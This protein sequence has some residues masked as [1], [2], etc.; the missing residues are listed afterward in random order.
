MLRAR[1]WRK[2]DLQVAADL[3]SSSIAKLSKIANLQT[4]TLLRIC[5]A[6]NC[7]I[8]D[9]CERELVSE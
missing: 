1:R 2:Q 8:A 9:I 3:S 5:G 6:L 4:D 7:D